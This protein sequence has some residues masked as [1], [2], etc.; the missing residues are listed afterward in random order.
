V[1][2]S[3]TRRAWLAVVAV[4]ALVAGI[5]AARGSTEL[6][7]VIAGGLVAG[8]IAA[9]IVYAVLRF[10]ARTIPGYV[11]AATIVSA[12]E[13]AALDGTAAGWAEFAV[14]AAVAVAIGWA[15]LRYLERSGTS[16]DA[17]PPT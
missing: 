13:D 5:A 9:A 15:A 17:A 14:Y 16:R 10:D 2:A 8:A 6:E 4:V 12:G 11:V 3:W 1:T 7:S